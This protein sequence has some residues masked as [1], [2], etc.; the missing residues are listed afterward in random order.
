MKLNDFITMTEA[1]GKPLKPWEYNF[2]FECGDK[3]YAGLDTFERYFSYKMMIEHTAYDNTNKFI[4]DRFGFVPVCDPDGWNI[5]ASYEIIW[6][7]YKCLWKLNPEN[8][9]SDK[10]NYAYI[11]GD[12]FGNCAFG[13]DTMNSVLIIL[14]D[15]AGTGNSLRKIINRWYDE[16]RTETEDDW[17][18]KGVK[19]YIDAYHTLGNFVLV[20]AGFNGFRGSD[21]TILDYWDLSLRHLANRGYFNSKT[22]ADFNKDKYFKKYINY[23]FLWDYVEPKECVYWFKQ[24]SPRD[25]NDEQYE[26]FF[27]ETV[28]FINRRGKFMTAM[29]NIQL[30]KAELYKKIQEHLTS[31]DFFAE[32]V[33]DAAKKILEQFNGE[34]PES[35]EMLLSEL[36]E[37]K[38]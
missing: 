3:D 30:E 33:F 37:E 32:S 35:A 19:D 17:K 34:I 21:N 2:E 9:V 22:K 23:F 8:K 31:P 10:S 24:I 7:I 1:M 4:K 38:V 16:K 29:I 14:G 27:T 25:K 20:P 12:I 18:N 11:D 5:S 13:A 15:I 36:K 28:K 6:D 26:S